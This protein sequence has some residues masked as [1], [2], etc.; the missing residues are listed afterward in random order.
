MK[1]KHLIKIL[2]PVT[3]I[4]LALGSTAFAAA[5]TVYTEDF[6]GTFSTDVFTSSTV[7]DGGQDND[8]YF[9]STDGY[10]GGTTAI[11]VATGNDGASHVKTKVL[12]TLGFG[13]GT[14]LY[15]N[16]KIKFTS[17]AVD[18]T[19]YMRSDANNNSYEIWRIYGKSDGNY[20]L[21]NWGGSTVGIME[22]GKWYDLTMKF[23]GSYCYT[24]IYDVATGTQ[25]VDH[26]AMMQSGAN[27]KNFIYRFYNMNSG[28]FG[29]IMDDCIVYTMATTETE[30]SS[31]GANITNGA[32]GI[33]RNVTPELN[34]THSVDAEDIAVKDSEGNLL[35][36][37]SYAVKNT[38]LCGRRIVFTKPLDKN[39]TYTIDLSALGLSDITFETKAQYI[40]DVAVTGTELS[41]E[42]KTATVSYTLNDAS[43]SKV[44]CRLM[45]ILYKDGKMVD[46]TVVTLTNTA[47]NSTV[48]TPLTFTEAIDGDTTLSIVFFE[49]DNYIP[50]STSVTCE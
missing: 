33:S 37:T 27:S 26:L 13:D 22:P 19:Y 21:N 10:N 24:D 36:T 11:K 50:L 45:G 40:L 5:P 18:G 7:F 46:A 15:I 20:H 42:N 9:V 35:P 17:T 3:I 25:V 49:N 4:V 8:T 47:F 34:F 32:D 1:I 16:M 12:S 29:L 14:D 30:V 28:D 39:A 41:N 43:L 38:G 44:D 2:L 48:T 31:L 6:D 23:S